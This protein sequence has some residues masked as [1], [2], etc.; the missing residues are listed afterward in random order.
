[1]SARPDAVTKL[2][3][4]ADMVAR[5]FLPPLLLHLFLVFPET[6]GRSRALARW[7]PFLYLP[8]AALLALRLD[9]IAT[10]GRLSGAGVGPET[11][12]ALDRAENGLFALFALAA[13]AVLVLRVVAE[14]NWERARQ[15]R[16]LVFGV[17]G[18]YLPAALVYLAPTALGAPPP[19]LV[20]A[21][22]L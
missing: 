4:G 8:A 21:V 22:A 10:G 18:G 17:A 3:F 5:L 13:V 12:H 14:E 9:L 19:E 20:A 6:L 7:T 2:L 11:L 1:M 15:V 16:W